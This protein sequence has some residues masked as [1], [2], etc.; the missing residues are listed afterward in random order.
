MAACPHP[1]W[2]HWLSDAPGWPP[3]RGGLSTHPLLP[4]ASGLLGFWMDAGEGFFCQHAP[5]GDRLPLP[6]CPAPGVRWAP[7]GPQHGEG[8]RAPAFLWGFITGAPCGL[9]AGAPPG[10]GLPSEG[11]HRALQAVVPR[12]LGGE[13]A[14]VPGGF[15]DSMRRGCQS[16]RQQRG[17][18]RQACLQSSSLQTTD[19]VLGMSS[20]PLQTR[21]RLQL[22]KGS[23]SSLPPRGR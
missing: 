2:C 8:L 3:G 19:A 15:A 5:P 7:L 23:V 22:L 17:G 20:S 14:W 10:P 9:G 16:R 4:S 12:L 6:E 11:L 1:S 13:A 18:D 21:N